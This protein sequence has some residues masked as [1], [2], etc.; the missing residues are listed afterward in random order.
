MKKILWPLLHFF[1]P[2]LFF[3]LLSLSKCFFFSSFLLFFFFHIA[4]E[5]KSFLHIK[6]KGCRKHE[7]DVK[8][9]HFSIW[10][11]AQNFYCTKVWIKIKLK[12][13]KK[14]KKKFFFFLFLI[15]IKFLMELADEFNLIISFWY[16]WSFHKRN[17]LGIKDKKEFFFSFFFSFYSVKILK[18]YD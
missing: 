6:L 13:L 2:C 3:N 11:R 1:F 18:F 5:E 9:T 4:S 17:L 7:V 14:Q 12:K 8:S 16:V 15:S 10:Q